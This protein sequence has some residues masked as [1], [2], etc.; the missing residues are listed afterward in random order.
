M[1]NMGFGKSESVSIVS[2]KKLLLKV[3]SIMLMEH[4]LCEPTAGGECNVCGMI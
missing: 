3:S 1:Y 2:S 4:L